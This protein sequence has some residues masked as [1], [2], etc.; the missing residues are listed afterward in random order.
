IRPQPTTVVERQNYETTI[1]DQ[2]TLAT[3]CS[4]RVIRPPARYR[5]V[6][7]AHVAISDSSQDDLLTYKH[8][9]EDS[10]KEKWQEA[11]L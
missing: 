2:N 1:P 6:G 3:R 10:D 9:M 7:E 5:E 8:I 4:G 11:M